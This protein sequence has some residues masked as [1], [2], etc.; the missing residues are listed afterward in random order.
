MIVVAD[1]FTAFKKYIRSSRSLLRNLLVQVCLLNLTYKSRSRW[2]NK[3]RHIHFSKDSDWSAST[4]TSSTLC[5][6][7]IYSRYVPFSSIKMTRA[8]KHLLKWM[9]SW[10]T[11]ELRLLL[12]FPIASSSRSLAETV[13]DILAIV[14]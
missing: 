4:T 5:D 12:A 10:Q 7:K 2:A 14:W 6:F 11:Y 1:K 13:I 9:K 8:I 3:V